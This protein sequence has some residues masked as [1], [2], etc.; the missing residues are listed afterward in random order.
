M[1]TENMID[2]TEIGLVNLIKKAYLLSSPQG[3]GFLHYKDGDELTPDEVG[4]LITQSRGCS[5]IAVRLDYVK[6]RAC[7]LRVFRVGERL[8]I[9]NSW[10]DH[11]ESDLIQ[12][13]NNSKQ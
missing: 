7:K 12:L 5:N 11:S 4:K 2:V 3:F 10:Y 1:N 8:Y 13:I 6:G 9:N